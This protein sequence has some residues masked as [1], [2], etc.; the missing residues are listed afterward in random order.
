MFLHIRIRYGNWRERPAIENNCLFCFREV[1][2]EYGKATR[3][4]GPKMPCLQWSLSP[5]V[6]IVKSIAYRAYANSLVNRRLEISIDTP[7][8]QRN[9]DNMFSVCINGDILLDSLKENY[10]NFCSHCDIFCLRTSAARNNDTVQTIL[11][12]FSRDGASTR[13]DVSDMS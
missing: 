13:D 4:S 9:K 11:V 8:L 7:A 1:V 6:L 10:I 2:P 12:T 5:T 3:D